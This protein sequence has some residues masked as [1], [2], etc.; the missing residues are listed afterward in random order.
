[1]DTNKTLRKIKDEHNVIPSRIAKG[2]KNVIGLNVEFDDQSTKAVIA[3]ESLMRLFVELVGHYRRFIIPN[4][5][6][7]HSHFQVI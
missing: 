7:K 4:S 2:L 6:N 5:E 3:T 1:L